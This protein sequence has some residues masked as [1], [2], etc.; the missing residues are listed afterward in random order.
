[1]SFSPLLVLLLHRNIISSLVTHTPE[2]ISHSLLL[3]I[4]PLFFLADILASYS[5]VVIV[6]AV[7]LGMSYEGPPTM[8]ILYQWHARFLFDTAPTFSNHF[9]LHKPIS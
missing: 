4:Y 7:L 5:T 1:M 2:N 3:F 6:K 9:C 8:S